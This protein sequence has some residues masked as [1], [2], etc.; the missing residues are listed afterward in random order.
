MAVGS[1]ARVKRD[2]VNQPVAYDQEGLDLIGTGGIAL[3]ENSRGPFFFAASLNDQQPIGA[4]LRRDKDGRLPLDVRESPLDGEGQRRIGGTYDARRGQRD[5]MVDAEGLIVGGV[6]RIET[7][8]NAGGEEQHPM[9]N[10]KTVKK[11][12]T[13][14]AQR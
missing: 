13:S 9:R 12:R 4:R 3:A 1:I 14:N 10:R 7:E 8:A 2:A 5:S 11:R 6:E